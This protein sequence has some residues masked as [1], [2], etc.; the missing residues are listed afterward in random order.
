MVSAIASQLAAFV[1]SDGPSSILLRIKFFP[2]YFDF[3]SNFIWKNI[4]KTAE[5]CFLFFEVLFRSLRKNFS[6]M[7]LLA[8]MEQ[9]EVIFKILKY[10]KSSGETEKFFLRLKYW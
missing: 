7:T 9:S 3:S 6:S 4:L 10:S 5:Y 1:Q 2:P 8:F